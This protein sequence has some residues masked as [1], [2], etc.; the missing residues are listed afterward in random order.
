MKNFQTPKIVKP[1]DTIGVIAPASAAKRKPTK[2][3]IEYLE[4]K[5][6]KSKPHHT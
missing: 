4:K 6:I 3:G 5:A 1:G 2:L